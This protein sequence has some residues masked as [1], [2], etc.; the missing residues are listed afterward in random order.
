MR[1]EI[2]QDKKKKWRWRLIAT[3]GRK[4]AVSSEGY[5]GEM[6][7]RECLYLSRSRGAESASVYKVDK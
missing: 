7:C 5:D 4:L 3:N 2:Y 6:H 1:Y